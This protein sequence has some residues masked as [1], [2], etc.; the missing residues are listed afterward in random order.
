MHARKLALLLLMLTLYIFNMIVATFYSMHSLMCCKL[1]LLHTFL[2]VV[3]SNNI[4]LCS[5][6]CYIILFLLIYSRIVSTTRAARWPQTELPI[7]ITPSAVVE[8]M[9]VEA[10][11]QATLAILLASPHFIASP[12]LRSVEETIH[13]S[14]A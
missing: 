3:F 13:R 2:L 5:L 10:V 1:P 9:V 11:V 14:P 12:L 6:Q 4:N 8:V 7:A